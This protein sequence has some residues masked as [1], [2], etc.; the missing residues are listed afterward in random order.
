VRFCRRPRLFKA[1]GAIFCNFGTPERPRRS[2]GNAGKR[3]K[4]AAREAFANQREAG[5]SESGSS[6]KS[7]GR[8]RKPL[9]SANR[10]F[11][12]AYQRLQ[13]RVLIAAAWRSWTSLPVPSSF[14]DPR[15]VL[16][17]SAKGWRRFGSRIA[18]FQSLAAPFWADSSAACLLL[19]P[20]SCASPP[21]SSPQKGTR[22]G[23]RTGLRSRRP[24]MGGRSEPI[25][26]SNPSGDG[27]SPK[28]CRE[29]K[30][31]RPSPLFS[32]STRPPEGFHGRC[33]RR[34]R[35]ALISDE[36]DHSTLSDFLK[37]IVAEN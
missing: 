33:P 25:P 23:S 5:A 13:I 4:C 35:R 29:L 6:R 15:S 2:A 24:G 17:S 20:V 11:S 3:P 14:R 19:R 7:E 32:V 34:D 22:P 21:E 8:K 27:A 1:L 28:P 30:T 26:V 9:P 37:A 36:G 18:S 10:Y 12:R 16:S 31:L